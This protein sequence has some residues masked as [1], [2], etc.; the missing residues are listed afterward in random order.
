MKYGAIPSV[1]ALVLGCASQSMTPMRVTGVW[2]EV[3]GGES[4]HSLASQYGAD[5]EA[6]REL[7]DLPSDGSLAGRDEVFVPKEGG[8]VPGTG[9]PPPAPIPQPSD[10][11][12]PTT[13]KCG[14]AERPCFKWPADGKLSIRFS[15]HEGAHHDGIDIEAPKGTPVRSAADGTV[16][17]S[18]DAIKGYG[19]LIIVRH[20]K[21]IITVY[22][23]N[24]KNLVKEGDA[25]KGGQTIAEVGSSGSTTR[26]HLHFEVRVD[27]TPQDPLLY[28]P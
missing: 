19:N 14:Q 6:L 22:A 3:K 8:K 12:T 7:N 2:H 15:D 13:G 25:V 10:H 17:Y 16:L 18:G 27:E 4:V 28:L 26:V 11:P 24:D 1:I 20:D 9:A 5:P 23:H 21:G